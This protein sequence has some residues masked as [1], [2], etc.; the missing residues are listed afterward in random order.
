MAS[1]K[2][3]GEASGG[4]PELGDDRESEERE[5]HERVL[6]ATEGDDLFI[7]FR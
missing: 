2:R 7:E 5:V 6:P 4:D 1:H 3:I